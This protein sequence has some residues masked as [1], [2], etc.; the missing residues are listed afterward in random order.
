M[1]KETII[2]GLLGIVFGTIGLYSI[3][4]F[5]PYNLDTTDNTSAAVFFLLFSFVFGARA[6]YRIL[7]G[8]NALLEGFLSSLLTTL[9]ANLVFVCILSAGAGYTFGSGFFNAL[10]VLNFYSLVVGLIPMLIISG[11]FGYLLKLLLK[12]KNKQS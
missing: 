2:G 4:A 10:I 7:Q 1:G 6:G 8:K 5:G 3:M 12:T 11:T 9:S